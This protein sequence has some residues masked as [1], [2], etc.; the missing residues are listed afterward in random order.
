MIPARIREMRM[1][2]WKSVQALNCYEVLGHESS[3]RSHLG[4]LSGLLDVQSPDSTLCW[5]PLTLM[6]M[7]PVMKAWALNASRDSRGEFENKAGFEPDYVNSSF[8]FLDLCEKKF[9]SS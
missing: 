6:I 8:T 2:Q 1:L 7:W 9:F 3:S 4:Q 5:Q